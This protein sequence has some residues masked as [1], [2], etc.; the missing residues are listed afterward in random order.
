[1][2]MSLTSEVLR[3]YPNPIFIET[4]TGDGGGVELADACGFAAIFTIDPF[5]PSLD[6]AK[7]KVP[8][9]STICG[10]SR[11]ALPVLLEF[12][13]APTTFWLDAHSHFSHQEPVTCVLEELASIIKWW[14][15]GSAVLIDDWRMFGGGVGPHT[16][17]D[18]QC[19]QD[20]LLAAVQPLCTLH[21]CG[22]LWEDALTN[23][24]DIMAIAKR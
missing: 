21:D 22:V 3:K 8:R 19:S 9:I 17:W 5:R 10:D 16:G 20:Q 11:V 2:S 12:T 6:L 18:K 13:C 7:S 24:A 4:G 1:M 15:P 23:K 14:K